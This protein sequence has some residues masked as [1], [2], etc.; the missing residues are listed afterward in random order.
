MINNLTIYIDTPEGK[1]LLYAG[2]EKKVN[3]FM[4]FW[5]LYRPLATIEIRSLDSDKGI[6]VRYRGDSIGYLKSR[7]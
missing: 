5:S 1:A 7:R 3:D 2:P 4:R 6:V